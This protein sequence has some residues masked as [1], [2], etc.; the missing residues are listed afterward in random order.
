MQSHKHPFSYSKNSR[1]RI[2]SRLLTQISPYLT[3]LPI[4]AGEEVWFWEEGGARHGTSSLLNPVRMKEDK[5]KGR[6]GIKCLFLRAQSLSQHALPLSLSST[7]Q[8]SL[9]G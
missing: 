6:L 8:L 4:N 3:L 7:P 9:S 2:P 5:G 1:I